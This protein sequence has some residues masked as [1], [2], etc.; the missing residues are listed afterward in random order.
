MNEQNVKSLQEQ[1]EFIE[2]FYKEIYL[3]KGFGPRQNAYYMQEIIKRLDKRV[4][5]F[6]EQGERTVLDSGCA[7][8]YGTILLQ[9]RFP[10]AQVSGLEVCDTAVQGGRARFPEIK[11]IYDHAGLIKE[12]YDVIISSHCLEHYL[13]PGDVLRDLLS[14]SKRYCIILVP[15]RE[16]PLG[17]TH[18]SAI[19]D[20]VFP[21]KINIYPHE[22]S[23]ISSIVFDG[24]RNFSRSKNILVI[25]EKTK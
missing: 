6:L 10:M 12:Y 16:F 4:I 7:M 20:N 19:N 17:P 25:Y 23:K 21:G 1:R 24:D 8:G 18:L 14:K 13:A 22:Y 5:A 3:Q 9:Q 15:Y 11:F 2:Y